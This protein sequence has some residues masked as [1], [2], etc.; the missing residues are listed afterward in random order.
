MYLLDQRSICRR[1]PDRRLD[2]SLE[3]GGRRR[4]HV[5]KP[6]IGGGTRRLLPDADGLDPGAVPTVRDARRKPPNR[7]GAAEEGHIEVGE[8]GAPRVQCMFQRLKIA[9][10][11]YQ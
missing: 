10:I 7:R 6:C 2:Q 3:R 8:R 9:Y 11:H 4:G 5:R 1:R